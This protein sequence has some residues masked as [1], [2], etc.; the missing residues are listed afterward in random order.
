[1]L[2]QLKLP[3]S[4]L[5]PTPPLTLL[6]DGCIL[7]Y[8]CGLELTLISIPPPCLART[9]IRY[10][11]A[12]AVVKRRSTAMSVHRYRYIYYYVVRFLSGS[13]QQRQRHDPIT[14]MHVKEF[15]R[16]TRRKRHIE[17]Y[18][19]QISCRRRRLW[20]RCWLAG[21]WRR[22]AGHISLVDG[23]CWNYNTGGQRWGC[24]HLRNTFD[25]TICPWAWTGQLPRRDTLGTC[26]TDDTD[27]LIK[28]QIIKWSDVRMRRASEGD[29]LR[30]RGQWK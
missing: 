3:V 7:V 5:P 17:R 13:G 8:W 9:R 14:G 27:M 28:F 24:N 26:Y 25:W 6:L 20:W 12:A 23:C 30:Y 18:A 4:T 11:S 10:W 21:H 29:N 15:R 16:R 1:M 2:I 19:E 22:S